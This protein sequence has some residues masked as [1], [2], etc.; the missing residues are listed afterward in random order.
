MPRS[1][2]CQSAHTKLPRSL[3]SPSQRLDLLGG[4]MG[5]ACCALLCS[6]SFARG[7]RSF[8]GCGRSSS[9]AGASG[10][11]AWGSARYP[12]TRQMTGRYRP[13]TSRRRRPCSTVSTRFSCINNHTLSAP[14]GYGAHASWARSRARLLSAC[15]TLRHAHI[16]PEALSMSSSGEDSARE[17]RRSR[18]RSPEA[19]PG[20][21]SSGATAAQSRATRRQGR[22]QRAAATVPRPPPPS[23]RPR[24]MQPCVRPRQVMRGRSAAAVARPGNRPGNIHA[25]LCR[26][27]DRASSARLQTRSARRVPHRRIQP[28]RAAAPRALAR[29]RA[30]VRRLDA[31][32][33]L[34]NPS[35]LHAADTERK[36]ERKKDLR[37]LP[38]VR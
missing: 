16:R 37:P 32:Q 33:R 4:G 20:P 38:G 5:V 25:Q 35:R 34:V 15:D 13:S 10:A 6:R 27:S 2:L 21:S 36:K 30:R 9:T 11:R 1:R 17:D 18:S 19:G 26:H 23:H 28:P 12:C 31:P 14:P 7:P 29:Q 8:T 22:Q 24:R 3:A